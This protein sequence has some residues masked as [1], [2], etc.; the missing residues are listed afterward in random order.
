[1]ES[2][3]EVLDLK[4]CFRLH[5]RKKIYTAFGDSIKHEDE[6]VNKLLTPSGSFGSLNVV[7]YL[8]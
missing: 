8:S 6:M 5:F 1:M 2:K 4:E 3:A 7:E